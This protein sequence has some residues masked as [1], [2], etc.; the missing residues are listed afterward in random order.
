MG[1]NDWPYWLRGGLLFT[2][3]I[4][5]FYFPVE[6]IFQYISVLSSDNLGIQQLL[7]KLIDYPGGRLLSL[8][9]HDFV[10]IVVEIVFYF[11]IGA[12]L[13]L[14]STSDI[15]LRKTR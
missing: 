3:I 11:V 14:F 6:V 4:N 9:G 7:Q 1:W 15:K 5:I 2:A 12:L 10:L 13:V 8:K